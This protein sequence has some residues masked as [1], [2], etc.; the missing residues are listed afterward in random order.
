[1]NTFFFHTCSQVIVCTLLTNTIHM[2][3]LWIF[4]QRRRIFYARA[5]ETVKYGFGVLQ[6]ITVHE[7]QRLN[8]ATKIMHLIVSR[9]SEI[10]FCKPRAALHKSGSNPDLDNFLL[11]RREVWFPFLTSKWTGK[12]NLCRYIFAIPLVPIMCNPSSKLIWLWPWSG[13]LL[14]LTA[15]HK[16]CNLN[17]LTNKPTSLCDYCYHSAFNISMTEWITF[18]LTNSCSGSR[19]WSAVCLLG[20]KWRLFGVGQPGFREG[21]EYSLRR[22]YTRATVKRK[23]VPFMCFSPNLS[24][25]TCCWRLPGKSGILNPIPLVSNLDFYK[26]LLFLVLPNTHCRH[27]S[28]GRGRWTRACPLKRT[29]IWSPL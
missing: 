3:C 15:F 10:F 14:P 8:L 16:T 29:T 22:V 21:V 7:L 25:Y 13:I 24:W 1:M 28:C 20:W 9:Y 4:I 23:Q 6:L 11:Q 27:W 12:Y 19:Q 17:Y 18:D 2:W 26:K 5:T